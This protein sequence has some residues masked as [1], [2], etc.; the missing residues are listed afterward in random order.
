MSSGAAPIELLLVVMIAT[1]M[2]LT[3]LMEFVK[4]A[5]TPAELTAIVRFEGDRL[6]GRR[7]SM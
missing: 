4:A 3:W 5:T 2:T 7:P 1:F 6:V